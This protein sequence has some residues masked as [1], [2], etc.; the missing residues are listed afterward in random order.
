MLPPPLPHLHDGIHGQGH[1]HVQLAVKVRVPANRQLLHVGMRG[2]N[3][4]G[5]REEKGRERKREE[6]GK[7]KREEKGG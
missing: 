6:R 7:G 5:K 1:A 2:R 4:K 3:G